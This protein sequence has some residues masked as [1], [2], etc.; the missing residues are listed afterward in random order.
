MHG[1][2]RAGIALPGLFLV[3]RSFVSQAW[4]V[5]VHSGQCLPGLNARVCFCIDGAVADN[6]S[7]GLSQRK[8]KNMLERDR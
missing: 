4:G 7:K 1:R 3:R 8:Q 5:G 2:C 6:S